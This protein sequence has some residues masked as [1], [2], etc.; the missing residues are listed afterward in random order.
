MESHAQQ[1]RDQRDRMYL[2]KDRKSVILINIAGLNRKATWLEEVVLPGDVT[3]MQFLFR[4]DALT[5]GATI[6]SII[7]AAVADLV[8]LIKKLIEDSP[9]PVRSPEILTLIS[10]THKSNS[11][12]LSCSSPVI[13]V[14]QCLKRYYILQTLNTLRRRLIINL[15]NGSDMGVG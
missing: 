4:L 13:S 9:S 5:E 2:E 1:S 14:V 3:T 15:G 8:R 10:A 11:A 6:Q 12:P 7:D